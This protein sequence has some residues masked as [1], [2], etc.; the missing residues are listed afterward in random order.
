MYPENMNDFFFMILDAPYMFHL[1]LHYW[2]LYIFFWHSEFKKHFISAVFG[3]RFTH[4]SLK[5]FLMSV[6]QNHFIYLTGNI[7]I[8]HATTEV[9]KKVTAMN[10]TAIKMATAMFTAMY[11]KTFTVPVI[12]YSSV[13][14]NPYC[15]D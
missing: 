7:V 5:I 2:Y 13:S 11:A 12:D 6:L 1:F 8:V 14:I 9:Q 3:C 10:I 15:S 4:V